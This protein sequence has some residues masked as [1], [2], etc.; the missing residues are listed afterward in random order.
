MVHEDSQ[1]EGCFTVG[2]DRIGGYWKYDSAWIHQNNDIVKLNLEQVLD[3]TAIAS[4]R[5]AKYKVIFKESGTERSTFC[6]LEN[7]NSYHLLVY[8][9]GLSVSGCSLE[10]SKKSP[11]PNSIGERGKGDFTEITPLKNGWYLDYSCT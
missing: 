9:S 11:M 2:L 10:I 8:R 3:K 1:G 7:I 5:Y 4:E 6:H